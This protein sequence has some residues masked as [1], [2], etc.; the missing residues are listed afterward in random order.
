MH[1]RRANDLRICVH[2]RSNTTRARPVISFA[3]G[4]RAPCSDIADN[5]LQAG[6]LCKIQWSNIRPR[7]G[8]VDALD[9]RG[10][11]SG[12]LGI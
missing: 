11:I 5:L 6:I 9:K 2:A 12:V 10:D 7:E 4:I 8:S 3:S 1:V